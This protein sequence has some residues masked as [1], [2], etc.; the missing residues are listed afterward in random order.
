MKISKTTTKMM[1][2]AGLALIAASPAFGA[3]A[4]G[5][6]EAAASSAGLVAIGKGLG[7]GLAAG[8][9]VLGGG[10]GIG[11][12]GASAVEAIARQPEAAGPIGQ[13]MILS[14]ALIE[15]ATL[16]AVVV[17]LLAIFLI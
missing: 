6:A 17:G 7:A 9:A 3:E 8:L 1:I 10:P 2:G 11:R 12:V 4:A 15:G 16:F 13:N 14:A 5:A